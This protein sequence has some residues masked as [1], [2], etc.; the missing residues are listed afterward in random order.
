MQPALTV[1]PALPHGALSA[2]QDEDV[3]KQRIQAAGHNSRVVESVLWKVLYMR[4]YIFY[5]FIKIARDMQYPL[6]NALKHRWLLFQLAPPDIHA[7][8]DAFNSGVICLAGTTDEDIV[9][10]TQN[11]R[12][13]RTIQ[14]FYPDSDPEKLFFVLDEAQ[15]VSEA[16]E[17]R[18]AIFCDKTG[19]NDRPLLRPILRFFEKSQFLSIQFILSGTG[20][21][22]QVFQ[23]VANSGVAK[24]PPDTWEFYHGSGGFYD[25]TAQEAYIR[26]YIPDFFLDTP[27]GKRLLERSYLWLRGR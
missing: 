15:I 22:W 13:K 27:S 10:G 12:P 5:R 9:I 7:A 21:S 25:Q 23:R 26:Q 4:F 1:L 14:L 11:H 20:F 6:D 8:E 2:S 17:T 3:C 19:K 18:G 16:S 24:I